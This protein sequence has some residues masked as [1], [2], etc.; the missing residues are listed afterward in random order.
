M[1]EWN[2]PGG[3]MWQLDS[4][5]APGAQ[6]RIF[7]ERAV[8]GF[9]DGFS[10]PA[11]RYGIPI[12]HIEVRFVNDH[13]Y[14]RMV[15]VGAPDPKPGKASSAPPDL[16]MWALARLHP[17]LRRRNRAARRALVEKPWLDDCRR[18]VT[19]LR[20]SLLTTSR[21]LQAEALDR[22][23]DQAIV[24]HL[25]RA[26]DHYQRGMT[27]HFDLMAAHDIPL[28]RFLVACRSWGIDPADALTLMAGSSPASTASTAGL[29]AIAK[30]CADAGIDPNTLEGVRV[31]GPEAERA[32][33]AYLADHGW[34]VVSQ[35]SPRARALIELPG[36]VLQAI[37][38]AGSA[39]TTV[40]P[41]AASIRSRVPEAG[42]ATFDELLDDA[43]R[44]YFLRDDN[45]A[46]TFMWPAG[47]VRRAMLEV[48][49]RLVARGI[50]EDAEHVLVLGEAEIPAAL[51]GRAEVTALVAERVAHGLAAE[52]A[53]APTILGHDEGPPPDPKL[54]PA[55]MAELVGA[56]LVQLELEEFL[57]GVDAET[58]GRE[59]RWDGRGVGIGTDQCVG[60]ACVA[61]SA[62][63]A[64]DRLRPGDVLVTPYT[65]PAYEA[66]LPVAGAV[67]T[68][69][70]GLVSHAAI[71]CR[72]HGIPAVL[73]VTGA[74]AHIP[75][76]ALVTVDPSTSRV[77]VSPP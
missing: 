15:P 20:P 13:C 42:R 72:E 32:L 39:G 43:R 68:E 57:V 44:T 52:A 21:A 24:D 50:L 59:G 54:F 8:P 5:H 45:V 23:D 4:A 17:E 76:G 9:G 1:I 14:G 7:Q 10:R 33:D 31:A 41:D 48:G 71:V 12:D 2:A 64:L 55:A 66:I 11:A 37:R 62:D 70:G 47:L 73:G 49:R 77:T 69:S 35:Y 75:D 34:R 3:G 30:A 56:I 63:E 6:P 16:V 65:T 22:L 61:P 46:L 51:D 25:R 29:S 58:V 28:G 40:V 74:T 38:A 60:R 53:G 18:W 26:A 67:V 19:E 27:L 36:V